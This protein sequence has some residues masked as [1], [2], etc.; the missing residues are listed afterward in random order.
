MTV[1]DAVRE[2]VEIHRETQ[3]DGGYDDG[4]SVNDDSR[5]LDDLKG[6][7]SMLIPQMIRQLGRKLGQ[8]LE[9]GTRVKNI[10][11]VDH[12]NQTIRQ[13]AERFCEAYLKEAVTV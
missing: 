8:P 4:D 2:L 13:I 1:D 9:K 10:Y 12:R 3:F 7:D 6:F 5:P 11:R